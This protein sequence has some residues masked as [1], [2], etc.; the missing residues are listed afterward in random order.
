[1]ADATVAERRSSPA[2][3]AISAV[4]D[5]NDGFVSDLEVNRGPR[6]AEIAHICRYSGG[7]RMRRI[8]PYPEL[9]IC[10]SARGGRGHRVGVKLR[11]FAGAILPSKPP[12]I[13]RGLHDCD[14]GRFEASLLNNGFR[15]FLGHVVARIISVA[16]V[17]DAASVQLSF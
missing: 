14:N 7:Q 8:A 11:P 13:R 10:R 9:Q 6:A 12:L 5:P 1:M 4:S 2:G 17:G 15:K 3:S 16:Q